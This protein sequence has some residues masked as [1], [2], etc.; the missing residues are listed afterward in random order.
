MSATRVPFDLSLPFV[1][2][3]ADLA[4]GPMRLVRGDAFPWRQLDVSEYEL[5]QLWATQTLDC[6]VPPDVAAPAAVKPAPLAQQ[7]KHRHQR[8]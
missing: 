1:V 5:V 6:I 7:H 8:R 2:A 4:Y 3:K